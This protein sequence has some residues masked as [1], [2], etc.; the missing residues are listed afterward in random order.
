[1]VRARLLLT[2][3]FDLGGDGDAGCGG[4]AAEAVEGGELAG[5]GLDDVACLVQEAADVAGVAADELVADAASRLR[6]GKVEWYERA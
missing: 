4:V 6:A 2:R 5:G 3:W 1:M